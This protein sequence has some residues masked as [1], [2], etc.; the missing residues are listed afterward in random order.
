MFK[1]P[2]LRFDIM[3]AAADDEVLA[4]IITKKDFEDISSSLPWKTE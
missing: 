1:N 2:D 3:C 4:M